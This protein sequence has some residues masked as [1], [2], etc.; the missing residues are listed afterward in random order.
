MIKIIHRKNCW[1][2]CIDIEKQSYAESV[3]YPT[4]EELAMAILNNQIKW[5]HKIMI[6]VVDDND[7]ELSWC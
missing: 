2:I 1:Q 5:K 7:K 4:Q 3:S 6:E